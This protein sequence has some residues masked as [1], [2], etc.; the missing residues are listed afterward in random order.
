M[1][2]YAFD[3]A[4]TDVYA[5][6]PN[7]S[8]KFTA[9]SQARFAMADNSNQKMA[10]WDWWDRNISL[11]T[12]K[13]GKIET[14]T[15]PEDDWLAHCNVNDGFR[16]FIYDTANLKMLRNISLQDVMHICFSKDGQNVLCTQ[17]DY[18]KVVHL[19]IKPDELEK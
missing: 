7:L 16:L 14:L 6:D 1:K 3:S 17:G 18:I 11:M 2:I 5:F 13:T 9:V 10:Y 4:Q 19:G 12:F 15:L 8:T